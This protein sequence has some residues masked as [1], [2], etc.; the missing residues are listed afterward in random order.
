ME[1]VKLVGFDSISDIDKLKLEASKSLR[2]DNLQQNAFNE[3]DSHTSLNKQFRI[4]RLIISFY[5][6]S[7][8]LLE[9]KILNFTQY[10]EKTKHIREQIARVKFVPEENPDA[11]EAVARDMIKTLEAYKY[12]APEADAND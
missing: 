8:E 2:E 12:S 4:L 3:T 9:D 5:E 6:K 10:Y 1:I 7:L 11:I